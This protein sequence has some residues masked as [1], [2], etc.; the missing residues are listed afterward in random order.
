[1]G[2][3]STVFS[4]RSPYSG[5]GTEFSNGQLDVICL[6]RNGVCLLFEMGNSTSVTDP[7]KGKVVEIYGSPDLV[8]ANTRGPISARAPKNWGP[9]TSLTTPK[10]VI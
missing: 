8:T 3:L 5:G 4:F 1:M 6:G 2:R 9:P 10:V 7:V